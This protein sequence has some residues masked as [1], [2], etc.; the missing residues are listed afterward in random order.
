MGEDST[1][2]E[3]TGRRGGRDEARS[4]RG[5]RCRRRRFRHLGV[6]G[7]CRLFRPAGAEPPGRASTR[8]WRSPTPSAGRVTASSI[9]M[10]AAIRAGTSTSSSTGRAAGRHLDG[11]AGGLA[12]AQLAPA[13]AR[14]VGRADRAR[15][16]DLPAGRL[17][18]DPDRVRFPFA[19]G[20]RHLGLVRAA[21]AAPD[22]EARRA[23]YADGAF[24]ARVKRR[25]ADA[26][27]TTSSSWASRPKATRARDFRDLVISRRRIGAQGAQARRC[28]EGA[29]QVD[30]VDLMFD[31]A[32]QDLGHKHARQ[33][34]Q[35]R[36]KPRCA[37]SSRIPT[38]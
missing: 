4:C 35:L 21:R 16:A 28:R 20:V 36:W 12:R 37:R 19:R 13:A 8:C 6:Q 30:P 10:S 2:R 22:D 31:L 5:D 7:P 23:V 11:A 18:A 9:T 33:R 15:P 3:A 27:P 24:R 26:G 25:P 1:E 34:A 32:R 29:R 14:E 17:P 38:C